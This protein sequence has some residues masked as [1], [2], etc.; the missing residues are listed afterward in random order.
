VKSFRTVVFWMHL[1]AGVTA[2][3]VILVMSVTGAALALKPQILAAVD[4]RVRTVAPPNAH[5]PRLGVDRVVSSVR[6]AKPDAQPTAVTLLA[7]R[8]ASASVQLGRDGM[9]YVDPYTGQCLGEGSARAQTF[10]RAMEDWHRWL[11]AAGDRRATARSISDASNLAFFI[12]AISGPYLWW[13]R[14]WTWA[15]ARAIL[16]FRSARSG[17]ARDFN[18]HNVI[19]FWCSPILIIL[20]L[21]GVIMSYPWANNLLYRAAGNPPRVAAGGGGSP[22]REGG[23]GRGPEGRA[24][25][26]P[27]PLDRAW[28][29]AEAQVPTWRS[30]TVRPSNRSNAPVAFTIVDGQSWNAFARS[31]LTVDAMSGRVITWEPYDGSSR[32]QKARLFVRFAH[33]GEIGG[34]SAQILAGLACL[35]G[36]FLVWTGL[37]LAWR[38]LLGWR[39]RLD[40]VQ[41]RVVQP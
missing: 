37:A 28:A 6:A 25:R 13:P 10:F 40:R 18:W 39:W 8:T 12:L 38:R 36:A 15:N 32:G 1:A 20:T 29:T 35:G 22:T 17:R 21:S 31:Q 14:S 34:V 7:D 41:G 26:G 4:A 30:M 3:I 16:W 11:G 2:G 24:P 27:Q 5:A 33:T 23:P 9:V 19:G